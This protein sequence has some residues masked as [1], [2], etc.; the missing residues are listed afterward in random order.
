MR[1]DRTD[2]AE[3]GRRA[4]AGGGHAAAHGDPAPS[5]LSRPADQ[6]VTLPGRRNP[7]REVTGGF[8]HCGT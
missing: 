8:G 2:D 6:L 3:Q 7:A 5:T 1:T 4:H